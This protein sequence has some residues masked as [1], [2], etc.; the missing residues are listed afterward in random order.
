MN[1]DDEQAITD[2]C[3]ALI[4]MRQHIGPKHLAEP[5]PSPAQLRELFAAAA[6]APDHKQL[7]PWRFLVLGDEARRRLSEVFVAALLTRDPGALPAHVDDARRKAFRG[8]VLIMAVADLRAE[9]PEVHALERVVSLGAAIQNLL[10]AAQARGYGSGLSS[11][12]ALQSPLLR[13]AFGIA[14][15]EHAVCFISLGTPLRSKSA[16]QRPAVDAFVRWV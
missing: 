4:H 3:D 1:P 16:R 13:E 8:P 7:T 14:E 12:R 15:G 10:L 2:V 11:G 9:Q 6:A 5:G